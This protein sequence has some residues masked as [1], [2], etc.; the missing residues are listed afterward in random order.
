MRAV[1]HYVVSTNGFSEFLY[2]TEGI[3]GDDDKIF[4]ASV[5]P[6]LWST[7]KLASRDALVAT[8]LLSNNL[9]RG[10]P[11]SNHRDITGASYVASGCI[12]N[13]DVARR[14]DQANQGSTLFSLTPL[15]SSSDPSTVLPRYPAPMV[16][17]PMRCLVSAG[18]Y[19]SFWLILDQH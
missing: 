10:N 18:C 12:D 9:G 3:S 6:A 1:V 14:R 2:T 4:V 7:R 17:R 11:S 13:I 8:S 5:G 16:N 15:E 19:R